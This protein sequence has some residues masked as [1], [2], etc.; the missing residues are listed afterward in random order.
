MFTH[1]ITGQHRPA[2][3]S[4]H[5]A[6]DSNTLC[7]QQTFWWKE[8]PCIWLKLCDLIL[9]LSH[10]EVIR[11]DHPNPS[12][13][14][15]RAAPIKSLDGGRQLVSTTRFLQLGRVG[16]VF[17][18]ISACLRVHLSR[19]SRWGIVCCLVWSADCASSGNDVQDQSQKQKSTQ[20]RKLH[21]QGSQGRS[22]IS[23]LGDTFSAW[24]C[25]RSLTERSLRS[26]APCIGWD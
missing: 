26:S 7:S 21:G 9:Q 20:D 19:F 2:S 13:T 24:S 3:S 23:P 16:G 14:I 18:S 12:L 22:G 6:M 17:M 4:S 5:R 25:V 15:P 10:K 1:K 11:D 8:L